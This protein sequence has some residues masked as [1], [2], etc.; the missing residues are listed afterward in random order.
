MAY[1]FTL[2][3]K[4]LMKADYLQ[5]WSKPQ[6]GGGIDIGQKAHSKFADS[7]HILPCGWLGFHTDLADLT[8]F[9]SCKQDF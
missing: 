5:L 9:S 1:F 6:E 2:R 4:K 7:T 8:D 3:K